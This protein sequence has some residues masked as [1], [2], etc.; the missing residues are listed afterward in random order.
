MN[1]TCPQNRNAG[2][3]GPGSC[4]VFDG[5]CWPATRLTPSAQIQDCKPGRA[6]GHGVDNAD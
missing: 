1:Q 5:I 3:D 2:I 6:F 4:F